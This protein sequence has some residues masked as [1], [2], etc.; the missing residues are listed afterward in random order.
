MMR[1]LL[2]AGIA[3][4]AFVTGPAMAADLPVK[5]PPMVAAASFN[6]SRCYVGAHAGYGWGRNRNDF[7]NAIQSGPTENEG[8]Q[9]ITVGEFGP[10]H[11]NTSGGVFGGQIG[12]NYQFAPN[13]LVGVEGEL[14]WSGIKGGSTAPEDF[15]DPGTFSRFES[16]NLWDADIALRFGTLLLGRNFLYVKVGVAWGNFRYTEWHDDFPST[17]A[18]PNGGT[19]SVSI[20]TT[21]PGLLLGIGWEHALT[22]PP[23][24]HWTIKLE[25]NYINYGSQNIAY[26]SAGAGLPNFPVRD[27][28]HVI[29]VGVNFYFP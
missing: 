18:C 6:W 23:G 1:K 12:C 24:D 19:C 28:K 9:A 26:P 22:F 29:K 2:L 15:A 25:Y 16:R 11:H 14:W 13:W 4:P 20:T 8:P 7:G 17:H 10:F 5:A 21:R 3:L 27:D